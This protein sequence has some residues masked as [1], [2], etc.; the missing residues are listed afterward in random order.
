MAVYKNG[1]LVP[2][3]PAAHEDTHVSGGSDDIDSALA[4][5]AIPSLAAA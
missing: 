5:A 4:D 3:A 1:V 2:V